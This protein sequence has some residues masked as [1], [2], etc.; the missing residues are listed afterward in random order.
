MRFPDIQRLRVQADF[1]RARQE[2]SRLECGPFVL[3]A[4]FAPEAET[5]PRI[6]VVTAK[7]MLGDAVHRN[8][9]RRV[10]REIFRHHPEVWPAGWDVVIVPRRTSLEKPY[11]TL[12][13]IYL[14][15]SARLLRKVAASR[16]PA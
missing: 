14:E 9:M 12:E 7:K 2:G 10:F 8:R 6:G 4:F 16:A 3:N 15:S 11:A 1:I 13:K 5:P